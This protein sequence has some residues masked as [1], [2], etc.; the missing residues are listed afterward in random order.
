L[1][2]R[3]GVWLALGRNPSGK[4]VRVQYSSD[5]GLMFEDSP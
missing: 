2:E 3:T 5:W 1:Q 4:I